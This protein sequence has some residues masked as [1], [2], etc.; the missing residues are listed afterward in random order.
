MLSPLCVVLAERD[1]VEDPRAAAR[2]ISRFLEEAPGVSL[3]ET[4][5]V[6]AALAP[7]PKVPKLGGAASP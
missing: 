1:P 4:Q 7:L 5:L 2:W 6:A 3:E